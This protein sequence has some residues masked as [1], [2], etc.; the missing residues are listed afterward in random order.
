[1]ASYTDAISQFNPYVAQL[2]VELMA[3]IGMQKQGLYDEGVKKIQTQI[4]NVAGMDVIKDEHKQYLQSK[5]NELGSNLKKVAGGDFSNAQLVNSVGG[6]ATQIIKDPTIQDAVSSTQTVRKGQKLLEEARKNGK[7]SPDNEWW[8]NGGVNDWLGDKDVKSKFSG[9]Y[10]EY[11]DMDKKL[12]EVADKVHE[13]DNSIDIP[14]I[15]QQGKTLYFKTEDV[16]DPKTGKIT[17]RESVSTD[18]NSGGQTRIDDAMLRVITK[19]KPAEK[20]L[21]NFMDSLDENDKQQLMITG[22]YHYRGA[23]KDTFKKDIISNYNDNKKFLSDRL[24]NLNVELSTNSNLTTAEKAQLQARAK[25]LSTQLSDGS[26]ESGL[27][28]QLQGMDDIKDMKGYKYQLYTQKYLGRLANDLSYESM[29]TQYLN[30][31]YFQADMDK[32]TLQATVDHYNQLDNQFKLT[33]QYNINKDAAD[34]TF[35]YLKLYADHP[36]LDPNNPNAGLPPTDPGT[37]PTDVEK[38]SLDALQGRT[39]ALHEDKL[40]LGSEYNGVRGGVTGWETMKPAEKQTYLDKMFAEYTASPSSFGKTNNNFILDYVRTRTGIENQINRNNTMYKNV[41]EKSKKLDDAYNKEIASEQGLTSGGKEIISAK[42]IMDVFSKNDE[43]IDQSHNDET[44]MRTLLFTANDDEK[45]IIA[46]MIKRYNGG[47]TATEQIIINK[48]LALSKKYKEKKYNLAAT[49]KKFESDELNKIDPQTQTQIGTLTYDEKHDKKSIDQFL[50]NK[51]D[52]KIKLGEE[53]SDLFKAH[54]SGIAGTLY[55]IEKK[56]DGTAIMHVVNS[57]AGVSTDVDLT[58]Q[59]LATHFSNIAK[60][61]QFTAFKTYINSSQNRTTN[62]MGLGTEAGAQF[63]AIG[64]YELPLIKNTGL[65]N[66]VKVDIEGNDSGNGSKSDRYQVRLYVYD[67]KSGH[68]KTNIIKSQE[69]FVGEGLAQA[70][71]KSIGP[72]TIDQFLKITP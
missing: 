37:L 48:A 33:M 56:F 60:T 51:I 43:A 34:K 10:I 7:S 42:K 21:A 41:F 70:T 67:V 68:W 49:K 13:I 3:K 9:H 20:I 54:Q 30:N 65:E 64:G 8:W 38:E 25:A 22:N 71:L 59:E 5:L 12:R 58:A 47:A 53:V 1:M 32:K 35:N 17:K 36:E 40:K 18:P 28:T 23:T 27:Q 55:S 19:G 26:L 69:G 31:P 11:K 44:L 29:Q 50:G 14:F 15:R 4:D 57:K 24:V 39:N 46:A 16:K 2:P 61:S 63:A 45:P 62:S 52:Q 72:N 66:I 6:M